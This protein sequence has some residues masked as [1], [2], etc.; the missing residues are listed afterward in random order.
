M[1]LKFHSS[2]TRILLS[3]EGGI[4]KGFKIKSFSLIVDFAKY[5]QNLKTVFSKHSLDNSEQEI[6]GEQAEG[7]RKKTFVLT[8]GG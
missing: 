2:N 5:G 1:D 8:L 4:I 6:Y 7:I 3:R